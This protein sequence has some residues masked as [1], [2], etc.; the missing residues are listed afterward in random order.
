MGL[1]TLRAPREIKRGRGNRR[2]GEKGR[3]M[4][5]LSPRAMRAMSARAPGL[6]GRVGGP[7]RATPPRFCAPHSAPRPKE[8]SVFPDSHQCGCFTSARGCDRPKEKTVFLDSCV[9]LDA[10]MERSTYVR[11]R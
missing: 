10:F 4:R 8:F 2:E 5:A 3:G 9:N 11:D 1:A 6:D 7:Q